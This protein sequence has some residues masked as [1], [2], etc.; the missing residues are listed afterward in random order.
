MVVTAGLY[1]IVAGYSDTQIAPMMGLLGTIIGYLLGK[2]DAVPGPV[3][4]E[5]AKPTARTSEDIEVLGE[6]KSEEQDRKV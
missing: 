2:T 1:L 3:N 5:P 6:V 4:H